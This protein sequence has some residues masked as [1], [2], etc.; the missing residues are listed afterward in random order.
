LKKKLPAYISTHGIDHEI[1]S[2]LDS[3]GFMI[4]VSITGS[5][6]FDYSGKFIRCNC[7]L[8]NLTDEEKT[9]DYLRSLEQRH[10]LHWMQSYAGLIELNAELRVI[11][12]NLA[13]ERIFGFTK[14]EVLGLHAKDIIL[15][16]KLVAQVDNA[17][18]KLLSKKGGE[19]EIIVNLTKDNREII[20]EWFNTSLTSET[21]KVIGIS[22]F[23]MD[24]TDKKEKEKI[25]EDHKL[26]LQQVIDSMVNGV[27]TINECDI[28]LSFNQSA[29]KMFGYKK[30]YIIGC[31][32]NILMPENIQHDSYLSN[33]A[34]T[35]KSNFIG[36]NRE[37]SGK[38]KNGEWFPVQLSV[39]ELPQRDAG[40]RVFVA[41]CID[42]TQQREMEDALRHTRKME[43]VGVMAGGIAHDFNN[44]LGV[45]SGNLEILKRF[46]NDN[47]DMTR[48]ID[49]GLKMTARG[50]NLT[51]RLLGFSRVRPRESRTVS[52]GDLLIE[53]KPVLEKSLGH[54]VKLTYDI[55]ENLWLVDI[56]TDDFEDSVVNLLINAKDAMN[57]SG[58]LHVHA[59]NIDL[60][61]IE[62]DETITV[63]AGE[64]VVCSVAD[65]GA[66]IDPVVQK[67]MFDPFYTTK[68][69][70]K[71][72]GLGLSMVQ[73]FI[74]RSNGSIRVISELGTGTTYCM[75]LPK[76]KMDKTKAQIA[77]RCSVPRGKET[78]L[79]VDDEE[80]LVEVTAEN[81]HDLGY[82]VLTATSAEQALVVLK[83][84]D[85][86]SLIFSDIIMPGGMDGYALCEIAL[87]RQPG[88]K[89]LLASGYIPEKRISESNYQSEKLKAF[90]SSYLNKPYDRLSLAK[91][92]RMILDQDIEN[93]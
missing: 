58:V 31:N 63:H 34:L 71:G 35:G 17:W 37:L 75:Y 20:C 84:T 32:L 18:S 9:N 27:I 90:S 28:I 61:Q 64:H 7:T 55:S 78:I 39:S 22:S 40:S 33:S 62:K 36:I 60:S 6:E 51:R 86:I 8:A 30:N 29:E 80:L 46:S 74:K 68:E 82:K 57:N 69:K 41:T 92:V 15:P 52:I 88:L 53:I 66:G 44:L 83:Q 4:N 38:R 73:S 91:R 1:F 25:H 19:H 67:K 87:K 26:E 54:R 89:V 3:A 14:D 16:K 2:V 49:S 59:Y 13:A 43:V 56:D 79:V 85:K 10:S 12:W 77:E 48:W 65:S 81:L 21:G 47:V 70:G 50:A 24:I 11:D 93:G 76:S 23:V 5:F 42:L 45:I 72:T